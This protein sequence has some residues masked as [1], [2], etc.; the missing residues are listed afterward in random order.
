MIAAPQISSISTSFSNLEIILINSSFQSEASDITNEGTVDFYFTV[1][2][3]K[4]TF[5]ASS[6]AERDG[7][8]AALKTKI[9]EAK[10]LKESVTSSDAYKNTHSS[11]S[12]PAMAAAAVGLPKKS[13][14]AKETKK[15]E[16]AEAKEEKKE[17]KE[18]KKEEKKEIKEEKKEEKAEAKEEKKARKSR[19]ASRKRNSI[20]GSI[21]FGKKEEKTEPKEETPAAVAPEETAVSCNILKFWT[22]ANRFIYR[23]PWLSLLLPLKRPQLQ[24]SLSQLPLL[25]RQRLPRPSLLRLSLLLPSATASS[26]LFNPNSPPRRRRLRRLHLLSQPRMLSLSLRLPQ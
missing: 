21:G 25:K 7:W 17:A 16:K 22:Q 20:F 11:L 3:H 6:L 13:T 26:E 4:H 14:E 12:K 5:Q 15:E 1:L 8:V 24:L 23:L 18:E 19:S 9:A 2:S 10:E